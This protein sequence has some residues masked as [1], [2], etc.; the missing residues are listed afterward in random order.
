VA[1]PTAEGAAYDVPQPEFW[2]QLLV[3]TI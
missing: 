2:L 3:V 1:A